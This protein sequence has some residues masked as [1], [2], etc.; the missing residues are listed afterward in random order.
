MSQARLTVGALLTA[1][2]VVVAAISQPLPAVASSRVVHVRE[3]AAIRNLPVA[4]HSHVA[5]YDRTADFG[6]WITQYGECDTRAVVLIQESLKPVTKSYYCTVSKGKWFS[7]YNATYYRNAYGGIVQID[8]TVP[9]ENVWISG[10]WRWTQATRVRYYNDLKDSRTLVGVDAHDNESKGDQDPT[11]W[12]PPDGTC[13]YVAY[14]VAVKT[15]WHLSVTAAEKSKLASLAASC[16]NRR[17][18]VT[19]AVVQYG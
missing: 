16:F 19:K 7:Y 14:W 12:L 15:R 9:V 18:T 6:D 2:A 1:A 11:T 17:L 4:E 3:R 5:S 8:H 10:A 13:R